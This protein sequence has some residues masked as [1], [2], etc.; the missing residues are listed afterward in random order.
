M[1]TVKELIAALQLC[2]QNLPVKVLTF[3]QGPC[4]IV[5]VEA[6]VDN[7]YEKCVKISIIE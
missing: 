7:V 5:E 4:E 6:V 1:M 3:E 2:D